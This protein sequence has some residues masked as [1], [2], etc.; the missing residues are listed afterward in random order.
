MSKILSRGVIDSIKLCSFLTLFYCYSCLAKADITAFAI[1]ASSLPYHFG[2]SK[3][4]NSPVNYDN[5]PSKYYNSPYNYN[6]GP[7]GENRVIYD[8][9]F[10]GY[11]VYSVSGVLNFFNASGARIG[12]IPSGGHTQ[13]IFSGDS[14]CGTLGE[15]NGGPIVALTQACYYRFLLDQ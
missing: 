2:P 13:S 5:S 12:I 11:Y 8:G 7:N 10:L 9:S 15:K 14:W 4:N 1:D 6:N 3:Y